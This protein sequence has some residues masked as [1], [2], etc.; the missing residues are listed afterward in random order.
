MIRPQPS[1]QQ[2]IAGRPRSASG[3]VAPCPFC[4]RVPE[5]YGAHLLMHPPHPWCPLSTLEFSAQRIADWNRRE[6]IAQQE[7]LPE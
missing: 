6:P 4:G 1:A 7:G 2:I 3:A 5:F